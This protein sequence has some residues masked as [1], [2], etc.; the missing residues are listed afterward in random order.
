MIA[1]TELRLVVVTPETTLIDQNVRSLQ[2]PL[3]DGQIGVLPG[4]APAVGRLGTGE[5]HF[6]TGSGVERYFIEGGFL[7]I[8]G[9]IVTLLTN[10]AVPASQIDA[11]KARAELAATQ[12]MPVG[13]DE[14]Y[15]AKQQAQESARRKIALKDGGH[16]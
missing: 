6:D 8:K 10:V 12:Q 15:A 13:T 14:E 7:Q 16:H 3:F 4:R 2:F 5:L 9:H 1:A 11:T